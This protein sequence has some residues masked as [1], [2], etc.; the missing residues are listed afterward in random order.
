MLFRLL[1]LGDV[2]MWLRGAVLGSDVSLL[3]ARVPCF[4]FCGTVVE[5][6]ELG[7]V[8]AVRRSH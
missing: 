7:C 6:I 3:V 8:F 2:G 1:F 5:V 4:W